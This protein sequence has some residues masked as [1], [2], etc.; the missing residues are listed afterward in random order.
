MTEAMFSKRC[1]VCLQW[2]DST[3]FDRL[4]EHP[5]RERRL[6]RLAARQAAEG[7]RSC[8]VRPYRRARWHDGHSGV[9]RGCQR[10]PRSERRV[11]PG[12]PVFPAGLDAEFRARVAQAEKRAAAVATERNADEPAGAFQAS[13]LDYTAYNEYV[14]STEWE[15]KKRDLFAERPRRCERCGEKKDVEVH[16]A[17]Y[18]RLGHELL[19]DLIILCEPCHKREH[20]RACGDAAHTSM[21][22]ARQWA[23]RE[24]EARAARQSPT[25]VIDTTRSVA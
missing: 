24:D 7:P 23:Y 25:I 16:H 8:P 19:D 5:C 2:K 15:Q 10:L 9:C 1:A 13:P 22:S 21:K 4:A 18:Q 17:T 6:I 14:G 20:G 3:A 12:N 11:N